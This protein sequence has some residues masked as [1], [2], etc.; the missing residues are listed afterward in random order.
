M[1]TTSR[2]RGVGSAAKRASKR[3][4]GGRGDVFLVVARALCQDEGG[5]IV[6]RPRRGWLAAAI[7]V[8]VVAVL[9]LAACGGDDDS[10]A[11]TSSA[12][13]A[14]I[15][16]RLGYVTTADH[17]YGVAV[18][19]FIKD[20]GTA[21][22]GKIA[23][24][25]LPNYQGGDV[26]LLRDVRGGAVEMASVSSA[27]W[28]TQGVTSFDALQA[29]GLITRLDL[30]REVITGPI[31]AQM[32]EATSAVGLKGLAIHEGG[33]RKPVGAKKPLPSPAAFKG[34]TIRTPESSVLETGIKG[35]GADPTAIPVGDIYAALRDGTV[36][37]ME[38]N[39]GL[40][41]TLKLYEVAKYVTANVTL[42]PFPTVLVMN[43]D[44]FDSLSA[45]QQQI[46]TDSANKVPGFSIDFLSQPSELP[47]TL[48]KEGMK[49][50]IASDAN[51]QSFG[52][53]SKSVIAEL[54]KN[55]ETKDYIDQIQALK[56]GLSAP[57][58]AA[59]LPEGCTVNS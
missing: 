14:E 16:L 20:V 11:D 30:E 56:D 42:W 33:L 22:G 4:W 19:Q 49:F 47:A 25:G 34:L 45:D 21:S 50:A 48:C 12:S 31:G 52:T 5:D 29:L 37:G 27:V 24:E 8:G 44:K 9:G 3:C 26:P 59:P 43:Q 39:L 15:T 58:A 55:A 46:I 7:A 36:D 6:R 13:S 28:G 53:A 32:L 1:L 23:I 10:S 40:I 18:N 38:A 54:S 57:P 41:Q 17:P 2:A 51:L 35:L